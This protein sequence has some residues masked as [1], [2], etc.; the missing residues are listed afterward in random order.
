MV[1]GRGGRGRQGI[2]ERARLEQITSGKDTA[3]GDDVKTIAS[4]ERSSL[5]GICGSVLV[6]RE[7]AGI[8]Q[9]GDIG[10]GPDADESHAGRCVEMAAYPILTDIVGLALDRVEIREVETVLKIASIEI[11][12]TKFGEQASLVGQ[13][14]LKDKVSDTAAQVAVVMNA[15]RARIK[16]PDA[17]RE[18][19]VDPIGQKGAA[20]CAKIARKAVGQ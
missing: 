18:I 5:A 1:V 6:Q 9:S 20:D 7:N 3:A 19:P 16:L 15:V 10:S 2:A 4:Q 12:I 17:S 13:R 14:W 11:G 8:C